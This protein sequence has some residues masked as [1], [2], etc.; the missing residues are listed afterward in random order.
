MQTLQLH[1]SPETLHLV[2]QQNTCAAQ[3]PFTTTG[4]G[5]CTSPWWVPLSYIT[6]NASSAAWS[7]FQSCTTTAPVYTLQDS[8]DWVKLNAEQ[9]GMYRVNYPVSMWANLAAAAANATGGLSA[10][11]AA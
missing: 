6:R 9:Y 10:R 8:S 7:P 3:A 1:D 5:T 2:A 4:P 11:G